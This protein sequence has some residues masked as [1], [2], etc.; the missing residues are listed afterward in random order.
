M[1]S[2]E[3]LAAIV[4]QLNDFRTRFASDRL[5]DRDDAVN[6]GIVGL[7][8]R[9]TVKPMGRAGVKAYAFGTGVLSMANA[10]RKAGRYAKALERCEAHRVAEHA[11]SNVQESPLDAALSRELRERVANALDLLHSEERDAVLKHFFA[12]KP[13]TVDPLVRARLDP[14]RSR[15]LRRLRTLLADLCPEPRC[16]AVAANAGARH[17]HRG[18]DP[19]RGSCSRSSRPGPAAP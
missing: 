10:R 1:D 3:T 14:L 5:V 6:E 7:L 11:S 9:G 13:P 4:A 12:A 19:A 18:I 2:Q 8:N 17:P 15:A 16:R